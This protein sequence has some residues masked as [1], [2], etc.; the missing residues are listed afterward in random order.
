MQRK[1]NLKKNWE[2]VFKNGKKVGDYVEKVLEI[3]LDSAWIVF[4]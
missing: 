3:Y 2:Y 4:L 1:T